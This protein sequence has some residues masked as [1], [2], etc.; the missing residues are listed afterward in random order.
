ME[1]TKLSNWLKT[2]IVGMGICGIIVYL[3]VF[4]MVGRSIVWEYPECSHYFMPWVV[5]LLITSIP[6]FATLYYAWKIATEI[7]KDNSFSLENAK[8]LK[9]ISCLAITDTIIFFVGNILFLFLSINHPGMLI[10]SLLIDF[11]GVAIA[12]A[13]AVLSHLVLKAVKIREESEGII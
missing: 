6:C 13:A 1:Q 10:L 12:I 3:F 11:G 7:G 4:P 2:V 8:S 9:S 5:F